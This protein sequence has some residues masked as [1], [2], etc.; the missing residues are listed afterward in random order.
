MLVD[1]AVAALREFLREP[2]AVFWVYVFPLMMVV[3]L[4][5]SL[6]LWWVCC[7]VFRR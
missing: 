6:W 7:W 5:L 4:A 3:A 2:A 1:K